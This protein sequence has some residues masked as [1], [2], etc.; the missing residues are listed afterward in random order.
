MDQFQRALALMDATPTVLQSLLR[1]IGPD[2][3]ATKPSESGWSVSDVL[4]HLLYVETA[5]I[6]VRIHAMLEQDNPTFA[7][8]APAPAPSDPDAVLQHWLAARA[9][10]LAYLRAL[11]PAQF[12][13]TGQHPRLGTINVREHVIEWAY[14]DLDH[15]RQIMD[16][17]QVDLY[18][19][20]G[21]FTALYPRA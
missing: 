21:V 4:D 18:S 12:D 3:M 15:L 7:A 11:S 20:I 10:N 16:C 13:R 1:S 14:H 8:G 2:Q 5:V 6:P 9:E 19:H 17:L